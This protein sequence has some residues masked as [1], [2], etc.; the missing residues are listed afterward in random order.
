MENHRTMTGTEERG[1]WREER[2]ET[3][4]DTREWRT[5]KVEKVEAM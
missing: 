5:G 3:V 2:E 1:E 4:T